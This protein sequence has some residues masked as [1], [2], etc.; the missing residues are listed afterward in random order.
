MRIMKAN[1]I[2]GLACSLLLALAVTPAA[3][4]TLSPSVIGLFPKELGEFAYADLKTARNYPWFAQLK[5]QMLPSRFREFEE[6]LSSVGADPNR[7]VE[8]LAWGATLPTADRGDMIVGVALGQFRPENTAAHFKN[9][10]TTPLEVRG[11][12]MYASRSGAGGAG[13]T[14]LYFIF[15]D[16]NTAAFGHR[17]VLEKLIEVR[18]G[19]E[20]SLL[21]NEKL[22]PLINEANG[23][24]LV[25]AVLDEGYT[26]LAVQQLAPETVQFAEAGKLVS[27]MKAMVIEIHADKGLDT[28][29]QFVCESPEDANLFAAILDAGLL[30]KRMQEREKNPTLAKTLEDARVGAKGERLEVRMGMSEETLVDLLRR[31]TFAVKL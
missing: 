21:R 26:K 31:N 16:A 25:W 18:F 11:Y 1:L 4:G 12:K 30:Y 27:K 10:K 14:D 23:K 20:E 19:A 29:F 5:D 8:E 22:T 17:A 6:F 3:A 2:R 24:G 9:L 13:S 28:R 7:Q 15:L